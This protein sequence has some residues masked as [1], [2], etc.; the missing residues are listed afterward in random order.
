[1]VTKVFR[2]LVGFK[3]VDNCAPCGNIKESA[4][5]EAVKR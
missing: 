5:F 2:E 4:E 3:N 1:V